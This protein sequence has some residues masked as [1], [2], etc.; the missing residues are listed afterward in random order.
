MAG[1][2]E[3]CFAFV[4]FAKGFLCDVAPVFGFDFEHEGGHC[5]LLAAAL[6]QGFCGVDH[7]VWLFY[8]FFVIVVMRGGCSGEI[9]K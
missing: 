5:G 3:E 6:L 1:G 4:F 7:F 9:R 2:F 8:G